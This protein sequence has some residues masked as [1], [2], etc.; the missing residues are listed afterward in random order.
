MKEVKVSS[1]R[2]N[3]SVKVLTS[4]G[5]QGLYVFADI[6][7]Y[8][9]DAQKKKKKVFL[10]AFLHSEIRGQTLWSLE[11]GFSIL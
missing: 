4:I 10:V 2:I 1:Q 5:K 6:S 7:R 3:V 11:G 9:I 8:C